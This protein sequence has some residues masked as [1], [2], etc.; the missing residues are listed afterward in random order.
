M[1][2]WNTYDYKMIKGEGRPM[3]YIYTEALTFVIHTL[4]RAVIEQRWQ[5]GTDMGF[6]G[7]P[8]SRQLE[9]INRSLNVSWYI[10]ILLHTKSTSTNEYH[11]F[12]TYGNV[13]WGKSIVTHLAFWGR[14][15]MAHN[16]Q[17]IRQINNKPTLGHIMVRPLP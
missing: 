11:L 14:D 5:W 13:A 4:L 12:D 9:S 1:F 17:A 15:K 2:L 8:R 3:L 7:H 6:C 16:A 10:Y